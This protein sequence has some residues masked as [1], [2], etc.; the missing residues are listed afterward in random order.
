MNRE[1]IDNPF[2]V[3]LFEVPSAAAVTIFHATDI[4]SRIIKTDI[5]IKVSI[6]WVS[7]NDGILGSARPGSYETNFE[8]AP[9]RNIAYPIALAERLAQKELN[10]STDFEIIIRLN[11]EFTWHY[12]YKDS[13]S[14]G[15]H[16]L[17]SVV[18][19][20]IGHGLGLADTYSV[21]G[22][23]A[24]WG[25]SNRA[26]IYDYYVYNDAGQQLLTDFRNFSNDLYRQL[27]SNRLVFAGDLAT[28]ANQD[29][30][31]KIY[32]PSEFNG[33]SSIAHLDES[34]FV[35]G[36]TN[37]LMTPQLG[38]EEVI[39]VT[40][41]IVDAMLAEMGYVYTF[42]EHDS[43]PDQLDEFQDVMVSGTIMA[44]SALNPEESFLV[45]SY[46]EFQTEERVNLEITGNSFTATI[47]A[48]G[49]KTVAGFYFDLKDINELTF[50][51]PTEADQRNYEFG[52]GLVTSL[53]G[54]TERDNRA[55]QF[56]PN[57]S[58]GRINITGLQAE[59]AELRITNS[60][61]RTVLSKVLFNETNIDLGLNPGVYVVNIRT[62]SYGQTT[63]LIIR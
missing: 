2:E 21:S 52:F 16:D 44:D 30:N 35:P 13:I 60:A 24:S 42:I 27:T 20:E 63:K 12:N 48:P 62:R 57:P 49:F 38:R 61:G 43:V 40:G 39:H 18:L 15:T 56:Y 32:A 26:N 46:D 29:E 7:L 55:I 4:W 54:L 17:L 34:T 9:K 22:D 8:G 28:K 31:P 10:D 36:D 58:S 23:D 5:P 37:S 50:R 19:H 53:D 59:P 25:T 45:Y 3:S 41:P 1:E 33:G 11:K 6:T 51:K 47:P 14:P